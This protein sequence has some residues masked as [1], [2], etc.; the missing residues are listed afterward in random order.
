MEFSQEPVIPVYSARP[1]QVKKDLKYIHT[2][3]LDK[4]EVSISFISHPKKKTH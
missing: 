2:A 1:D 3:A 4:L